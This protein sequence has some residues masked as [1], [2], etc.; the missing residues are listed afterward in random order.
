MSRFNTP[1]IPPKPVTPTDI[2]LDL[3]YIPYSFYNRM[4]PGSLPSPFAAPHVYLL[5]DDG[6]L[7]ARNLLLNQ[8]GIAQMASG[9]FFTID[10]E[11]YIR[12]LQLEKNDNGKYE[13]CASQPVKFEEPEGISFWTRVRAFFGH[14]ASQEK[15]AARNEAK[16]M[17]TAFQ[18][19]ARNTHDINIQ[20]TP[21][22]AERPEETLEPDA[23][24]VVNTAKKEV[25]L[26]K[27]MDETDFHIRL[28]KDRKFSQKEYKDLFH[29][30]DV[31]AEEIQQG[32]IKMLKAEV[33]CRLHSID[34]DAYNKEYAQHTYLILSEKIDHCLTQNY[35]NAVNNYIAK[36]KTGD[37][38]EIAIASLNV[39][40][41]EQ[42]MDVDQL[43]D[44]YRERNSDDPYFGRV[45]TQLENEWVKRR[46]RIKMQNREKEVEHGENLA[47]FEENLTAAANFS[48]ENM[49]AI[50]EESSNPNYY[51]YMDG[52]EKL[53]T[54]QVASMMLKSDKIKNPK[55]ALPIYEALTENIGKFVHSKYGKDVSDVM[56]TM[57]A[58]GRE[59]ATKKSNKL[60]NRV[61][62]RGL[63]HLLDRLNK[64][65]PK[66]EQLQDLTNQLKKPSAENAPVNSVQ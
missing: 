58:D 55:A 20:L 35:K 43:I 12:Q 57:K 7:E 14:K 65:D 19:L 18:I 8:D 39:F 25:E 32:F 42:A 2:S 59:E 29:K 47:H 62:L 17:N 23:P 3:S 40:N 15:I 54:A 48:I 64:N 13:I 52:L 16:K 27:T 31:T 1:Y 63:G 26:K 4:W 22:Q 33:A 41:C 51:T 46:A 45:A 30:K 44:K 50:M 11:G 10:A 24:Q 6:V 9:H 37:Q 49:Q 56:E 66:N 38:N 34:N 5:N 21:T 53:M 36:L 61:A 60:I 28:H